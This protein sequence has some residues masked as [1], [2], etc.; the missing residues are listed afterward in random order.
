M[1]G[2]E[3]ESRYRQ[4]GH[5]RP[6][7]GPLSQTSGPCTT[8]SPQNG[9][10]LHPTSHSPYPPSLMPSSHSSP[11][12]RMP[13]PQIALQVLGVA[14]KPTSVSRNEEPN[15]SRSAWNTETL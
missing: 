13:S 2:S 14:S 10:S 15:L 5:P 8:P 7:P 3:L 9:P 12:L 11:K 6:P 1:T 4:P